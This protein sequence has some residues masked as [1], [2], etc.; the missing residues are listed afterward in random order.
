MESSAQY[1]A[2]FSQKNTSCDISVVFR[3][4]QMIWLDNW[5]LFCILLLFK[6]YSTIDHCISD[7]L[8]KPQHEEQSRRYLSLAGLFCTTL[9]KYVIIRGFLHCMLLLWILWSAISIIQCFGENPNKNHQNIDQ[10]L[11]YFWVRLNVFF[12]AK[13][14]SDKYLK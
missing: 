9:R 14:F 4:P 11:M 2:H 3:S 8:N 10:Y 5:L 6:H 12:Q 1:F 13:F 7:F